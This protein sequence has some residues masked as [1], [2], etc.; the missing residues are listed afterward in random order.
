MRSGWRQP[1]LREMGHG[2][3]NSFSQG[4]DKLHQQAEGT[5]CVRG[6]YL[7]LFNTDLA[8]WADT[9]RN[10][11]HAIIQR[12]ALTMKDDHCAYIN[13]SAVYIQLFLINMHGNIQISLTNF[14]L[15]VLKE[16][17]IISFCI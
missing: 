5:E 4:M 1:R 3:E 13:W 7:F 12:I 17:H 9:M 6:F 2:G 15:M 8:D 14:Y 16:V 11:G 10:V